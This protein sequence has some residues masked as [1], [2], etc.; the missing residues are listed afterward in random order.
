MATEN[1]QHGMN[2][3][4]YAGSDEP[5]TCGLEWR[6]K[7]QE[8][9]AALAAAREEAGSLRNETADANLKILSLEEWKN[10]VS[11]AIKAIPEFSS[12][13]WTGDKEGWGFHFE[14]VTFVCRE[15]ARLISRL[16]TTCT[17]LDAA[18]LELAH[19][20]NVI[21]AGFEKVVQSANNQVGAA[22]K[23][24]SARAGGF[25]KTSEHGY[26]GENEE[27]WLRG[28]KWCDECLRDPQFVPSKLGAESPQ[29]RA[30]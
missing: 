10:A 7:L 14:M 21:R 12:G 20:K 22:I 18:L 13:L 26:A 27:A 3:G 16:S 17:N 8:A 5:C 29:S 2:C 19:A 25:S 28:W 23:G 4:G 1:L 30:S 15:R 11:G 6:I 9:E 24:A